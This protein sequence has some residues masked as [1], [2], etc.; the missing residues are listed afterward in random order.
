MYPQKKMYI[1]RFM[2]GHAHHC[3]L[4]HY[5]LTNL[6]IYVI[7]PRARCIS[8][9]RFIFWGH[10]NVNICSPY[11][12]SCYNKIRTKC[13]RK[14]KHILFYTRADWYWCPLFFLSIRVPEQICNFPLCRI[15]WINLDKI[16]N[17][18]WFAGLFKRRAL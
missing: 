4:Q 9:L 2:T 5:P 3:N 13:W 6:Q 7:F 16:K 18:N 10:W 15:G 11:M 8:K 1:T 12:I 17:T 14:R